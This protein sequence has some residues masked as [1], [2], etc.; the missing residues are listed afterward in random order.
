VALEDPKN[1]FAAQN[2]VPLISTKAAT[3][4]VRQVLNGVS[5]KL[6]TQVLLDLNAELGSADRPNPDV[7]A[8]E[9]LQSNGLV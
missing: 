7:V 9:W 1:N 2:V 5:A 4:Q 6:T 3:D 8:K